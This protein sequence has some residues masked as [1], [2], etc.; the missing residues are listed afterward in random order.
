MPGIAETN[1]IEKIKAGYYGGMRSV[2]PS[3]IVPLGP[4][5]DFGA[6]HDRDRFKKAA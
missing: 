2:N 5:I 6:P 3:G 1:D 4:G